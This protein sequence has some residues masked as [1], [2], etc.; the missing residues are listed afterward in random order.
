M[1]NNNSTASQTESTYELPLDK[2]QIFKNADATDDNNQ[3]NFRGEIN[4]NGV[5]R[6][7]A[8]WVTTSKAGNT[9][10]KGSVSDKQEKQTADDFLS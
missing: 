3:P 8:L 2:I 10:L 4:Q 5:V 6:K 7:V 9:Y 1:E